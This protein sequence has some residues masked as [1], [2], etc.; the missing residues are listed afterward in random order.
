M[1]LAAG[2]WLKEVTCAN[3]D[4]KAP[5]QMINALYREERTL[6]GCSSMVKVPIALSGL[7]LP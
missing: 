1:L 4:I 3:E 2:K 7:L 5:T 6:Y